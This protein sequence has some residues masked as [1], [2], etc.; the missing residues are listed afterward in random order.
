MSRLRVNKYI[1]Y[2]SGTVII[3][4][5]NGLLRFL[6][7]QLIG[8][9][10]CVLACCMMVILKD[11]QRTHDHKTNDLKVKKSHTSLY[12]NETKNLTL[13]NFKLLRHLFYF[14]LYSHAGKVIN[15]IRLGSKVSFFK[16]IFF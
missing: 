8:C 6:D 2:H 14:E 9:F 3:F 12:S 4:V 11:E 10:K 7:G 15:P 16:N 5:Y 13:A 1:M